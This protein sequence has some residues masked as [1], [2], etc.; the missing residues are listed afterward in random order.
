MRHIVMSA[1]VV[2]LL[3]MTGRGVMFSAQFSTPA[4]QPRVAL[5]MGN[6]AYQTA[7]LRNPVHDAADMAMTL[8]QLG[9]DVSLLQ[10]AERRA[11]E[12]AIEGFN[13]QL[14]RGGIGLFYFAGHGVQVEGENYL[15]PLQARIEREQDVRYEAVPVGRVLAAMEDAGSEVNVVILDACRNN[16]YAR[17]WRSS[18]RGL[19]AVQ[20]MG[21]VLIAFATQPG[22]VA[23]DG[24]GRNGLYTAQLLRHMTTPGLNLE[25]MLKR[26]RAAVVRATHGKQIPWESSSLISEF[27]FVPQ[28][29]DS[30]PISPPEQRALWDAV[31]ARNVTKVMDLIKKGVDV[32]RLDTRAHTAGPNGRRPLNY[33]ALNNDTAMLTAL[34]EAGATINLANRSG[35]TPLH[36][37]GEAGAREAA[38][39]LI[40]QGA[41][42]TLRNKRNQTPIDTA[43]AFGHPDVAEVMR[44]ARAPSR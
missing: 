17:Q 36:H 8:R 9:F 33:A 3:L 37:A 7:P 42:P 28:H 13:R 12:D 21:G 29:D 6:A 43:I 18:Q 38:A 27:F 40:A 39:L 23:S 16:P 2:S 11:M 30:S 24:E 10:N 15:I 1:L 4:S 44:H 26:V 32:N 34:L 41:N 5:V 35:F 31:I 14:R 25:S 22:G 19:A 20:A